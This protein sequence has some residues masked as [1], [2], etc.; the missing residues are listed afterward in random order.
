MKPLFRALAVSSFG[1]F[2][3]L[4]AAAQQDSVSVTYA[5]EPADSSNFSLKEKYKYFTRATVE[6]KFMLKAG[7]SDLGAASYYGL[8]ME[9]VFTFEGKINVPFSMLAQFRQGMSGWQNS[10]VGIDVAVRYYYSLPRRIRKGK[11]ANNF[12]ANYFSV[13]I[14][15]TWRDESTYVFRNSPPIADAGVRRT[16]RFSLLYGIQRRLGK[17][18]YVDFNVGGAYQPKQ[19]FGDNRRRFFFDSNFS[20]G[21]AF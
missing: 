17:H 20:I 1:L 9:N 11:S 19:W 8:F 2:T 15:N 21:F 18:G 13:Q 12:S 7:L 6:E 10:H 14:D 5:E 16:S 4:T 3:Y